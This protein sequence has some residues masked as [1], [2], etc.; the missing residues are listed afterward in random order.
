MRR[1]ALTFWHSL[2]ILAMV[3]GLLTA[4][5]AAAAR[6]A[7]DWRAPGVITLAMLV[8]T[9]AIV[10]QRLMARERRRIEEQVGA[11]GLELVVIVLLVRVWSLRAESDPLMQ[12]I[13]P[14]LRSPLE[15]FGGRFAEYL[16]WT[17]IAWMLATLLAADV[18]EWNNDAPQ[19]PQ[20]Q[21]SIEREQLQNEWGQVVARY[22]RRY[23]ILVLI[24]FAAAAFAIHGTSLEGVR[25]T[26]WVWP[27]AAAF[28]TLIA[29][30]LLHSAGKLSQLRRNWGVDQIVVDTGI[31]RQWDRPAV[32]LILALLLLAPLVSWIVLVAPPPP[33]VPI[34]NFV[35]GALTIL[36]SII[37]LLLLSPLILL[38]SLLRG[39][40][41]TVPQQL[42]FQPPQIPD[43]TAGERPL[44]PALI[45]W[46]CIL[47][48]IGIALVHYVRQRSDLQDAL[49]RWRV[50][51]WLFLV[52]RWTRELWSDARGWAG[53]AATA[54][55]SFARR[56]KRRITRATP[57]GAQAQLRALYR[58]MREAGARRGVPARRA[59]TPF[60]YGAALSHS[61]PVVEEE[62]TGLTE[63]Y[64]VAEYGPRPA[65]SAEVQRARHYWRRMQRWLLRD[66]A[67][68]PRGR[69][70]GP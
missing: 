15:F 52:S 8:A 65:G 66:S 35:L 58:R 45:F 42:Q 69:R 37:F 25:A 41:P 19:G 5:V 6:F 27:A 55:R 46:G 28:T 34:A 13:G 40:A 30:M 12:T 64:V 53:L 63:A 3:W 17:L 44:F 1:V 51:R 24:S 14:W 38:L 56:R 70:A 2:L 9:E 57:G 29:G 16:L 39:Q 60:E 62:I 23:L 22:D 49:R 31:S 68:R 4:L 11:R 67:T 7:P 61:L 32:L 21:D 54:L 20:L 18:L 26:G 48:L 50:T 10:T 47:L 59:Q 36:V 43:A 33:L